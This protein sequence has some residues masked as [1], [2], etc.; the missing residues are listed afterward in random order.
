MNRP[1]VYH[2]GAPCTFSIG[3][4]CSVAHGATFILGGEHPKLSLST[5]TTLHRII[6]SNRWKGDV[7]LENDVWIGANATILSGVTIRTGAIIGAGAVI[8]KD[9]P[10]YAVVVGNPQRVLRYRFESGLIERLIGSHWWEHEPETLNPLFKQ[11]RDVEE[12]L[13]LLADCVHRGSHENS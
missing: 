13:D 12:F 7:I 5:N 6:P 2:W 10:P 9:V 4:F 3:H 8:T 1:T 11:S